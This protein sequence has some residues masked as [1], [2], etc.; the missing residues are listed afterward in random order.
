MTDVSDPPDDDGEDKGSNPFD[1]RRL[2]ISGSSSEG[3]TVRKII[4]SVQVR[5]PNRQEYFR[6][7]AN[8]EMRIDTLLFDLRDDR[9]T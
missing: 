3:P 5:K 1:P 6:V 7:H 8:P 4:A 9:L 2:R